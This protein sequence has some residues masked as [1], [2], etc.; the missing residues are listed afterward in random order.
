MAPSDLRPLPNRRSV[1]RAAAWSLPVVAVAAAA[2]AA[3]ASP[4]SLSLYT[5]YWSQFQVGSQNN[6][7]GRY[8]TQVN[9][10]N[11]GTQTVPFSATITITFASFADAGLTQPLSSQTLDFHHTYAGTS[12]EV[13]NALT[14][15]VTFTPSELPPP[16]RTVYVRFTLVSFTGTP[17]AGG[18]TFVIPRDA[19]ISA[20]NPSVAN[21]Y[22]SSY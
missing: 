20:A 4:I 22:V 15:T 9:I 21:G 5:W 18:T 2:P 16:G 6:R 17:T 1:S 13:S 10:Q 19:P 3:S 11:R 8:T 12:G 14:N 7:E